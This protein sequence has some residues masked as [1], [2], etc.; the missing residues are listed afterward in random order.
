MRMLS[1][2]SQL[3]PL[4]WQSA[5][6]RLQCQI[7]SGSRLEAWTVKQR[8]LQARAHSCRFAHSSASFVELYTSMWFVKRARGTGWPACIFLH[9]ST[10]RQRPEAVNSLF[11]RAR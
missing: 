4:H 2:F 6:Y 3:P 8:G 5:S 9:A 11:M 10:A 1:L 7:L